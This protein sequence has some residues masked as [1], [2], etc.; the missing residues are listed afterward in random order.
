M[1]SNRRP[2]LR[3]R[4]AVRLGR[5]NRW[6]SGPGS[7]AGQHPLAEAPSGLSRGRRGGGAPTAPSVARVL[8]L[9]VYAPSASS[10]SPLGSGGRTPANAELA[11]TASVAGP[12]RITMR[13]RRPRGSGRPGDQSPPAATGGLFAPTP[14]CHRVG[15]EPGIG[16]QHTV[17]AMTM[18]AR[19]WDE[20]T[21]AKRWSA[22]ASRSSRGVSSSSVRPWM[23][24]LGN[25]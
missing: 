3:L 6:R 21:D 9:S 8:P 20:G 5:C 13:W 18:H 1:N 17:V 19:G 7:R 22:R 24:G 10:Q 14:L 15:P 25:R 2:G 4:A 12:D 16:S 23:S 11:Y